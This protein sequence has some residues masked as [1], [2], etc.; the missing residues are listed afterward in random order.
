MSELAGSQAKP[1][2]V[3]M[4]SPMPPEKSAYAL[5]RYSRS[6][7]SIH[8]SLEWVRSHDSQKFLESFYFQYGHAS[9]A[10]LGHLAVCLEGISELAATEV[11]DEQLW[12]GQAKSTRYQ[13]FSQVGVITPPEFRPAEAAAY[14]QQAQAMIA[15]YRET[16]AKVLDWLKTELPRPESMKPEAYVRNL[17]A[18]A[19]DVARYLLFFGVPTNVGQVVSIRTLEKQIRRLKVSEYAEVRDLAGELAKACAERPA[20]VWDAALAGEAMAPTLAKYV[21]ADE[22]R[23]R[24][25]ADLKLWA[26]Q[27]L[28][29]P[30]GY[31][32]D[33]VDLVRPADPVSEIA[34][35][36]LYPVTNRPY[37]ELQDLV[38]SWSEE[39]KLEVLGVALQS[40]S[41]R[42]E[43]LR[44]FR[45]STFI[46]DLIMDLG[47]YRD[48]HRHRRCE[49][50][51]QAYS[52]ELG[53]ETPEAV[54]KAGLSAL[55]SQTME[56]TMKVVQS[57]PPPGSHYLLPFGARA[58]FLFKMDFA[59]L[60]YIAKLRSGVKGHFSY[61][62][63]AWEMK[64]K[65]ERIEPSLGRLIEATPPWEEDP[66]T[67]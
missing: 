13:D 58:R 49:Q 6:A 45:T 11:E 67:R 60:E 30:S 65:L 54:E 46:F 63:I 2:R 9:I 17:S 41:R 33:S 59:Q 27:N 29:P 61:R 39:R 51:R 48:L 55:Y 35:T 56:A 23:R 53:Y 43:L 66:L 62:R 47:A 31:K 14:L 32:P 1:A 34:A 25:R 7:D 21:S 16:H 64:R 5:A 57:L 24:A 50:F 44:E 8:Q 10:D 38:A 22:H 28:P 52:A 3:V 19:F 20:C 37:R 15:A 4:L 18:R 26:E 40:R 36:L 12:D 42:D